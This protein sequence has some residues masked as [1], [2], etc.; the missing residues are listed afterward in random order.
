MCTKS[1]AFTVSRYSTGETFIG[2]SKVFSALRSGA[3]MTT[4][5][6]DLLNLLAP[7]RSI[8]IALDDGALLTTFKTTH[9]LCRLARRWRTDSTARSLP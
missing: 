1:F 8:V 7:A 9:P 4:A 5:V 2:S 3:V 6:I